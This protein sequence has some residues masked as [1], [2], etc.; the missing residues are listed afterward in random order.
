MIKKLCVIAAIG[1]GIMACNPQSG[2]RI[3]GTLESD[4]AGMVYL[5]KP[6]GYSVQTVDSAQVT[7]NSFTLSGTVELSDVF[8]ITFEGSK[9]RHKLILDNVN[10]EM[11]FANTEI[12]N[13]VTG[14]KLQDDMSHFIIEMGS[15]DSRERE[16]INKIWRDTTTTQNEKDELYVVL[17]EVRDNKIDLANTYIADHPGSPHTP[18]VLNIYIRN[19]LTN[20]E[21]DSV[22]QTFTGEVKKTNRGNMLGK[23]IQAVRR[24]AV[25]QAMIDFSMPG[26]NG[27]EMKLSEL[28]KE[29]KLVFIDFWASWCGPCRA[30]IPELKQIYADYHEQGLE[31]FAVSYDDNRENWLNAI[32][33]EELHWPNASNLKGWDC[34]TA[35]DYAI[36]GIPASVLITQEGIIAAR[37]LRGQELRDKI[38]ELL[39]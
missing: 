14:N 3:S 22:Y 19:F 10:Y 24:S 18:D 23:S 27:E 21:L 2:Y 26:M 30:S 13:S 29:N 17:K 7:D 34:P 32:E 31:F 5:K 8:M 33:E 35:A 4:F 20:D 11:T 1:I 16:L 36:R 25:G 28:V 38:E 9:I 12:L 37:S 15:L 39:K 6:V